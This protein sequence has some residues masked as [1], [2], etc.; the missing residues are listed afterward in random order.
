MEAWSCRVDV[1]PPPALVRCVTVGST[2]RDTM[3]K[4]GGMANRESKKARPS[5]APVVHHSP[6]TIHHSRFPRWL[7]WLVIPIV[8]LGALEYQARRDFASV[9][10][11]YSAAEV[12]AAKN[13]VDFIFVGTSRVASA[14]NIRTFETQMA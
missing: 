5:P 7:Q 12:D 9:P 14:V 13:H 11:W 6:F 3:T 1:R 2:Q 4:P 10:E 8:V